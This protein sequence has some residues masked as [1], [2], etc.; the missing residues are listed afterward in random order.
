MRKISLG[1]STLMV[2]ALGLTLVFTGCSSSGDEEAAPDTRTSDVESPSTPAE[3]PSAPADDSSPEASDD[4]TDAPAGESEVEIAKTLKDPDIGDTVEIVSAVRDFPSEEKDD[5]ITEG[6]EVVLVQVTITPGDE[7]GGR[8]SDGNF[9]IS[10]DDGGDFHTN[11]TRLIADEMEDADHPA[12]E[13]ISRR[14]GGEHTGW[15]AFLVDEKA[16]AYLL[17]YSRDAAKVIGSDEEIDEFSEEVE[18]PAS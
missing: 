7:F 5:V 9:K 16:D 12:L 4:E 1:R 18:I 13:D 15:I 10:W 17:E 2:A 14:D 11:D 6:G 8:I 3:S